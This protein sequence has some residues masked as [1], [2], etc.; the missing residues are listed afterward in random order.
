MKAAPELQ[1]R[2]L[3]LEGHDRRLAQLAK[4]ERD[5]PERLALDALVRERAEARADLATTTGAL[6]DT[7][8]ELRRTEDDVQVV[9]ARIKRDD[10]R[11]MA[12][13]SAKD[14]TAFEHE[15]V[16]LRKRLGDLE[17]IELAVMER[18]EE[19]EAAA[20]GIRARVEELDAAIADAESAVAGSLAK[21]ATERE[22]IVAV[23]GGLVA[24]LPGELVDLYEKQRARYGVGAS[25][26]RRGVSEG[27]GVALSGDDIAK[28]R[29]AAPDDVLLCPS[30][31]AILVRTGE[32]GL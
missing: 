31:E 8:T 29:A 11:L 21:I 17:E 6:D 25:L 19:H 23:R 1:E 18:V 22:Q 9:E 3:E 26:L 16:S 24:A 2:L 13:S 4:L 12:S 5:L 27:S 20:A 10:E 7:R 28:V 14:V 32:S 30:S 15:I